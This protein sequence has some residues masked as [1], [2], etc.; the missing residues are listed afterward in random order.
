MSINKSS[1]L[2][3]IKTKLQ[4]AV[5]RKSAKMLDGEYVSM[6]KGKSLDFDDLREYAYGDD[7]K[8]IDWRASA[9]MSDTALV[10]QYVAHRRHNILFLVDT[11]MNLLATAPDFTPKYRIASDIVGILG[12][13]AAKYS[14]NVGVVYNKNGKMVQTALGSSEKHVEWLMS[15]VERETEQS[16]LPS[17]PETVPLLLQKALSVLRS[18]SLII[19]V[20]N[21]LD[22]TPETTSLIRRVQQRHDLA[23]VTVG[24]INPVGVP[25]EYKVVDVSDLI[26]IPDTLRGDSD[27]MRLMFE[28]EQKRLDDMHSYF[29]AVNVNATPVDSAGRT[30]QAALV[31]LQN[32]DKSKG[33]RRR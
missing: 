4:L 14:N 19:V 10:K 26:S 16:A 11:S 2:K 24:D 7:V 12:V 25:P 8:D 30:V 6:L 9:R 31:L 27:L 15:V 1:R 21:E 33:G 17:T 28:G 18:E 3:R 5:N 23:W 29:K 13:L 32:M 20:S 22:P